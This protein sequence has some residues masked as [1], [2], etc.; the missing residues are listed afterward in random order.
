M[1]WMFI[2]KEQSSISIRGREKHIS[3]FLHF[4]LFSLTDRPRYEI[5]IDYMLIY[6]RNV[7]KR[8]QTS[9]LI[10]GREFAFSSKPDGHMDWQTDICNLRVATLLKMSRM[11]VYWSRNIVLLTQGIFPWEYITNKSLYQAAGKRNLDYG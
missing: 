6:E 2:E 4:C 8:N 9:I 3:I 1:I 7:Y 10:S 5:F 11:I